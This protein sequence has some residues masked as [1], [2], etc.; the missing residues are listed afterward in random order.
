MQSTK[1]R[2]PRVEITKTSCSPQRKKKH[3]IFI[4][5]LNLSRE[6]DFPYEFSVEL[7]TSP[8]TYRVIVDHKEA[9]DVASDAKDETDAKVG[10]RGFLLEVGPEHKIEWMAYDSQ[11]YHTLP[12]CKSMTH[13][14]R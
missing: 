1:P 5:I 10:F 3:L 14:N 11:N 7:V 6:S 9:D 2:L 8:D 13:S 12:D 4:L